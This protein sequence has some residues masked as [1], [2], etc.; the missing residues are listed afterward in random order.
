MMGIAMLVEVDVG[1]PTVGD[2]NGARSA[3]TLNDRQECCFVSPIVWADLKERFPGLLVDS[4]HHP[5]AFHKP[6][7][8]EFS[9]SEFSLIELKDAIHSSNHTGSTGELRSHL[10]LDVGVSGS[11]G[12][13][14]SWAIVCVMIERERE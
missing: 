2:E 7:S 1:T 10:L 3:V 12:F 8:V 5:A 13:S 14:C 4:S 9:A 6:A 11:R